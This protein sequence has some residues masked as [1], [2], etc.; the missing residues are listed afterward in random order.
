MQRRA[1]D[2]SHAPACG[3]LKTAHFI[4]IARWQRK[5]NCRTLRQVSRR[6]HKHLKQIP[7]F[8]KL[9]QHNQVKCHVHDMRSTEAARAANTKLKIVTSPCFLNTTKWSQFV[10]VTRHAIRSWRRVVQA[11][12][13]DR[14]RPL[15]SRYCG[16]ITSQG[17]VTNWSSVASRRVMLP[18]SML[19]FESTV[20][21][22][23]PFSRAHGRSACS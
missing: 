12:A 18:T 11:A 9:W 2:S 6:S 21:P 5:W 16:F 1:L 20:L 23:F 22:T 4:T 13:L 3:A 14:S 7:S 15:R 8:D 19:Q 10:N 17:Y